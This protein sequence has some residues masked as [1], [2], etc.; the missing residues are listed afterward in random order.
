MPTIIIRCSTCPARPNAAVASWRRR[1][2][3][4]MSAPTLRQ[5]VVR[6]AF[7]IGSPASRAASSAAVRRGLARLLA[8]SRQQAH[9]S[10]HPMCAA[11]PQSRPAARSRD[12]LRALASAGSGR[13]RACAS[14]SSAQAPRDD[15]PASSAPRL[16]W[17]PRRQAPAP[18]CCRGGCGGVPCRQ[19]ARGEGG[20]LRLP[21][22]ATIARRR[23]PRDRSA[24][25]RCAIRGAARS[26][27][28]APRRSFGR[29]RAPTSRAR[30]LPHAGPRG[31][32]PRSPGRA[33]RRLRRSR[34]G[35][36]EGRAASGGSDA[37]VRCRT[38]PLLMRAMRSACR[39]AAITPLEMPR[40]AAADFDDP[41]VAAS[42][43]GARK[44]TAHGDKKKGAVLRDRAFSP[45]DA[46]LLLDRDL[47]RLAP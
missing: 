28:C 38:K 6:V 26:T 8:A 20:G 37:S 7:A 1:I 9:Q 13:R 27:T 17:R 46:V 21:A 18:P 22:S 5:Q 12:A 10:D 41:I 47:L 36:S 32:A 31:P 11:G 16:P 4:A 39:V 14:P 29:C 24:R 43:A 33:L 34:A 30:S 35:R 25:A 45:A 3:A 23:R 40:V 2:T 44:S 15:L 42:S 19:R